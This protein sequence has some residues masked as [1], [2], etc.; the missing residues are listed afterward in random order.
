[1][2]T[3]T[4][5]SVSFFASIPAALPDKAAGA[6]MESALRVLFARSSVPS[7]VF[8]EGGRLFEYA[9]RELSVVCWVTSVVLFSTV[10]PVLALSVSA[11]LLAGKGRLDAADDAGNVPFWGEATGAEAVV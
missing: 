10:A 1:M 8:A 7:L 9:F 11:W 6:D 2:A 4:V 5:L 3:L